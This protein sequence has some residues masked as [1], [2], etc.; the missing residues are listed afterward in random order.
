[1]IYSLFHPDPVLCHI[2]EHYWYVSS[3]PGEMPDQQYFYTPLLQA[4]AFSFKK[5]EEHYVL[6]DKIFTLNKFAYLFGQGTGPRTATSNA[7][8]YLG[9]KFRPLG[10]ARITGINM[11]HLA[12]QIIDIEDIWGNEL[13]SL[14]DEM[15]SSPDL[16]C[17]IKVLEG[18]LIKK[19]LAARV[20]QKINC[21]QNA[22]ALINHTQG[23]INIKNIQQQTNTSRK[24]LERAFIQNVGIHPKL[25]SR[26]VRF[27]AV[28]N[29]LDRIGKA[30]SLT[31]IGLDFGFYDNSHFAS[32]FKFFSG[33]TPLRYLKMNG[34]DFV[35]KG[36]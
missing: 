29:K 26:I 15:Q 32:E 35:F 24:T 14:L 19:Y 6:P 10:I 4:L 5:Q 21:A 36:F 27:N 7:V 22:L 2:V 31:S 33:L 3:Q 12:N 18:F 13:E 30:E 16:G 8:D 34:R 23:N 17:S 20:N 1:M 9:V 28:K 25:Y 11:A